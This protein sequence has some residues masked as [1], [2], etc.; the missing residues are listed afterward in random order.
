LDDL[1]QKFDDEKD[2]IKKV[3]KIEVEKEKDL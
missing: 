3:T 2:L 1:W